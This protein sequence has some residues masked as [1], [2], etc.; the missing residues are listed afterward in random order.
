M[1]LVHRRDKFIHRRD[2]VMELVK[3]NIKWIIA[4]LN[5]I[6]RE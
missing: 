2:K 6:Q 3:N 5:L 1:G 4:E